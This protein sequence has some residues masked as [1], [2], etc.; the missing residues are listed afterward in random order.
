MAAIS[1]GRGAASRLPASEAAAERRVIR[2]AEGCA[3]M[4]QLR[5][6]H[7]VL[8]RHHH[9]LGNPSLVLAKL[10]RFAAVSPGGDLRYASRLIFHGLHHEE[11]HARGSAFFYNTLIRGLAASADPSPA[12]SLYK[13]MRRRSVPPDQFSFTFLIKAKARCS[14]RSPAG[15]GDV[16]ALALKHGCLSPSVPHVHNALIHLYATSGIPTDAY[17]VFD[18]ML[19]PDVVS[20]SGLLAAQLTAGDLDGARRV[21]DSMAM[22]DVVSWTA[23]IS[24]YAQG[25][26]PLQALALFES[27]PPAMQPDEVT[28]VGVVSACAAAGDLDTGAAVHRYADE[29]GL[30]WMVSLR[31]ALIDMYAK[32]GCMEKAREVFEG[33]T[34]RNSITWNSMISA[35]AVHGDVEAALRL[36]WQL[37]AGEGGVA[38][39]AATFLAALSACA[40]GGWVEEG[41]R[42]LESMRRHGVAPAVEHYGCVVDMLGRAGRLEEAHRLV[43]G[44]LPLSCNHVL[45]GALL[46]ACRI[47]GDLLRLRPAEGGYYLLLAG[48]YAAAG[49]HSDADE[50]RRRMNQDGAVK[51]PAHSTLRLSSS[52]PDDH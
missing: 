34:R 9:R 12:V 16:H 45:W 48:V 39:D 35:H 52:A 40:H 25:G 41:R 3:N 2:A 30:G 49:R 24:G 7:G 28:L 18:E 44:V 37:A 21:F 17:Q 20:W 32:C 47:H 27:M 14:A 33:T 13:I 26:R 6:L 23:M 4:A 1:G 15:G 22:R 51:N 10:L 38:P 29:K 36:F 43:A 42:V 11:I 31:N 46:G 5:R 8:V 50:I 19:E